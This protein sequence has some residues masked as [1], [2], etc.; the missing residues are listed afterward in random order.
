MLI[1][2][3]ATRTIHVDAYILI[4]WTHYVRVFLNGFFPSFALLTVCLFNTK[5]S[6][7][8]RC[9]VRSFLLRRFFM[10]FV[11]Q[12]SFFFPS[13]D[14]SVFFCSNFTTHIY[15]IKWTLSAA[16]TAI[17]FVIFT[18]SA[19][20]QQSYFTHIPIFQRNLNDEISYLVCVRLNF[21]FRCHTIVSGWLWNNEKWSVWF[22]LWNLSYNIIIDHNR[23]SFEFC[24]FK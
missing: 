6:K 1:R 8:G 9:A 19:H 13:L 18:N 20:K 15:F 11:I 5:F 16:M 7:F 22:W 17:P 23:M 12:L 21:C 3:K 4:F 2:L 10:G 24:L 14:F